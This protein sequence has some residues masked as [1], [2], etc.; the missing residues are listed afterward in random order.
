MILKIQHDKEARVVR[1]RIWSSALEDKTYTLLGMLA[2]T[3][4]EF[5]T[6]VKALVAG[7]AATSIKVELELDESVSEKPFS[8]M[9]I[10]QGR[11]KDA[12]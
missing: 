12:S 4:M 10:R 5:D 6:F 3:Q 1:A 2:M 8:G 9:D 7:G 11:I